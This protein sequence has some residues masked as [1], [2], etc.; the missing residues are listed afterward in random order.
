MGMQVVHYCSGRHGGL[1]LRLDV[2][3]L[4]SIVI[5]IL[6]L[7]GSWFILF[8]VV[9]RAARA[10]SASWPVNFGHENVV[11]DASQMHCK[12]TKKSWNLQFISRKFWKNFASVLYLTMYQVVTEHV[13]ENIVCKGVS[14]DFR[15]L[16]CNPHFIVL[17]LH[18]TDYSFFMSPSSAERLEK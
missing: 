4:I 9:G 16:V 6:R 2:E 13:C 10:D 3:L 18:V 5:L 7:K 17:A 1:P 12:V 15:H 8:S 14:G 11:V